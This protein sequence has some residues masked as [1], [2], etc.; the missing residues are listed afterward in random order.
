MEA[1]SFQFSKNSG[2]YLEN[3]VYLELRR[4]N[5]YEL[6]YYKT[7]NNLEVDFCL[8]QGRQITT[9][10]QVTENL[11]DPKTR[12][13]EIQAIKTAM[14]ELKVNHGLIITLDHTEEIHIDKKQIQVVS[15][16]HWLLNHSPSDE[17]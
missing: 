1:I 8:Q 11:N 9:L 16:V 10:I 15:I 7:K 12:E 2:K 13:R 5:N 3:I 14:H 6:Y 4:R 17:V